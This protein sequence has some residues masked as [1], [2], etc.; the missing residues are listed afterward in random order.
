[1]DYR[2][3]MGVEDLAAESDGGRGV[4]IAILDSGSPPLEMSKKWYGNLAGAYSGDLDEFG[5]A[6]EIASMLFGGEGISGLCEHATPIFI[7][8]LDKDGYG[9]AES[10][11]NGIYEALDDDI[12]LISLSLGF[13]RT[14]KCPE[15][16]EKACR[17]AFD[18]KKTIICAAGNDGGPVNW[19]AALETT[20]CVGSSA[21]NGLKAAF[22]SVGEVDFVA[23]GLNLPVIGLDGRPKVVHGTSFS[24][25]LVAGVAALL[26]PVLDAPVCME[27][28]KHA[29]RLLAHDVDAPGWDG[30]TGYGLIDGGNMDATVCMKIKKG[31]FDRI[32]SKVISGLGFN[33]KRS[34]N[35]YGKV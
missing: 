27:S 20:I 15:S 35:G 31:I 23:P 9:S 19:P 3:L 24:S 4:R 10:V 18:S 14:E 2:R 12:D 11:V 1:M 33:K 7:K 25:A 8:V 16:L 17:D 28:V 34:K 32:F 26:L 29:L 21:E 6:T 22:S 30:K 5:H 13:V